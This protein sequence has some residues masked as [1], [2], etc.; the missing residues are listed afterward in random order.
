MDSNAVDRV[1]ALELLNR[2]F[3]NMEIV[4]LLLSYQVELATEAAGQGGLLTLTR[5]F[6]LDHEGRPTALVDPTDP[7]T[8][9]SVLPILRQRIIF[10]EIGLD[11]TLRVSVTG[12]FRLTVPPSDYEAWSMVSWDKSRVICMPGGQLA[13]WGPDP[14]QL[15]G[16]AH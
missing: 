13:I 11:S 15:S 10:L 9:L 14:T 12:G 16:G 5:A 4:Q 1:G 8:F 7:G 2:S 6:R 3:L